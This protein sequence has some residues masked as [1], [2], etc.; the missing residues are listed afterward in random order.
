MR[1]NKSRT[2]KI[3]PQYDIANN[4][5]EALAL[6]SYTSSHKTL[7]VNTEVSRPSNLGNKEDTISKSQQRTPQYEP[8]QLSQKGSQNLFQ[9]RSHQL[10][11][12]EL[13]SF[14]GELQQSNTS[15]LFKRPYNDTDTDSSTSSKIL[16][17]TN[18][19]HTLLQKI[20]QYSTRSIELALENKDAISRIEASLKDF[21]KTITNDNSDNNVIVEQLKPKKAKKWFI[22]NISNHSNKMKQ[23]EESKNGWNGYWD[24]VLQSEARL[25]YRVRRANNI[26]KI[27]SEMVNILG[28]VS[29]GDAPGQKASKKE[30]LAWKT[31]PVLLEA[32]TKLW[33]PVDLSEDADP[34]D[35]YIHH[36]MIE[37]WRNCHSKINQEFAIAVIEMMFDPAITT[38]SLTSDDIDAFMQAQTMKIAQMKNKVYRIMS[39]ASARRGTIN[40][41][42]GTLYYEHGLR[43]GRNEPVD[44]LLEDCSNYYLDTHYNASILTILIAHLQ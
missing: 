21:M 3:I 39:S 4:D 18:E 22:D 9:K 14:H 6:P 25:Q 28:K 29:I 40:T 19:D 15:T 17:L 10:T 16:K 20:M 11:H 34:Q 41:E 38:T 42:I 36:I 35:T 24:E 1:H 27:K 8:Q 23:I 30:I 31:S 2:N 37:V 7:Q 26:Q 44:Q 5:L 12:G 33:K 13:Q 32:K 43:S